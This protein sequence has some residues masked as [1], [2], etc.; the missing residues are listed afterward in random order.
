MALLTAD[1]QRVL[2]KLDTRTDLFT[3]RAVAAYKAGPAAYIDGLL[4][5]RDLQRP[6]R[7]RRPITSRPW[8]RIPSS[9]PRSRFCATTPRTAAR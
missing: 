9:S 8:M 2:R 6:G 3:E 7:S 4:V 1:L 5:V